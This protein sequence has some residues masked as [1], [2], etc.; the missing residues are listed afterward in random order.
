MGKRLKNSG[1]RK[2]KRMKKFLQESYQGGLL[3][4]C[5]MNS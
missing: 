3:Q 5:Y 4:K 2:K 1:N